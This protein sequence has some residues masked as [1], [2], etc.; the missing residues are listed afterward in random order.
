MAEALMEIKN[1]NITDNSQ[2][3]LINHLNLTVNEGQVN[4]LIG[5]SGSGKSLTA[6]TLIGQTPSN[7]HVSYDQFLFKGEPVT[8]FK[9]LLGHKIGYIS[10]DYAHSFTQHTLLG[11]QLV[12][13]YRTHYKV[14]K[15]EA[16][17]QIKKALSWVNLEH[18]EILSKYR[19]MLSG[20]QL[21]RLYIASVL[22]L[23]PDLI[24]ADEP[25]ASLDVLN[26]QRIMKLIKHLAE[27][28]DTTLL[29]ITHN[30]THV[31]QYADTINVIRNGTIIES[32]ALKHFREGQTH[33]YTQQL[34]NS[35]SRLVRKDDVHDQN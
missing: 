12:A 6:S 3:T 35:R 16:L 32:G 24:I 1:L 11:K 9:H 21:E 30:L 15:P 31:I 34:L 26:G 17:S 20:G 22:M 10:Q 27:E 5:E 33:P 25:V 4:V 7:L 2:H 29:L 19:F 18:T 28:H 13:I 23:E 8:A 14:S